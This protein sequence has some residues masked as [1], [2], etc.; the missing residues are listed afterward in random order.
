MTETNVSPGPTATTTQGRELDPAAVALEIKDL[1]VGYYKDLN[2]LQGINLQAQ[3]A[4]ITTI[5]GANGVGKSTLFKAIYGFLK[6]NKGQVLV[7][8]GSCH[9]RFLHDSN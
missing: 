6:P 9:G 8:G 7:G 5:L 1:Y 3:R 4:K 2:I